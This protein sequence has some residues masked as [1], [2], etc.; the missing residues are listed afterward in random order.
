MLV[1]AWG[2]AAAPSLPQIA[3]SAAAYQQSIEKRSVATTAARLLVAIRSAETA[4]KTGELVD[5]YEQLVALNT[6]NFRAWLQLANAWRGAEPTAEKGLAAAFNAYSTA[7]ATPDQLEALLLMS[8]FLRAR[9]ES[10]R[11]EYDQ[12]KTALQKA[13]RMLAF[14]N[15]LSDD[16]QLDAGSTDKAGNLFRVGQAREQALRQTDQA[17]LQISQVAANLDEIYRELAATVPGLNS[18]Q[19]KSDDSRSSVFDV[20]RNWANATPRVD[21][22]IENADVRTCIQFSQELKGSGL[23]YR[24]FVEVTLEKKPFAAFGVDVKG[25]YLCITGLE[26]GK[27]YSLKLLRG[28]PAKGDAKLSQDIS[29]ENVELPSLPEQVAFSGRQFILPSNGSGEV[30]LLLTNVKSLSLELFRVTD[31]TLH[32]HIALGHI[33]GTIPHEEYLELRDRFAEPLWK[34]SIQ[35]AGAEKNK[36]TKAFLGVR[37][38]LAQRHEWLSDQ[39]RNNRSQPEEIN[40]LSLPIPVVSDHQVSGDG[41]FQA[42]ALKFEAAAL[43]RPAPGIYALVTRDLREP[44][45]KR[46]ANCEVNCGKLLVQWFLNTDIGLSL[47]EG[48]NDFTVVAR[49]LLSGVAK[50]NARI[51]LISAGNRVLATAATDSNGVAKFPRSL[52]RG[53]Q[54]NALVAVF[55]HQDKDFGFITFGSERLNLSRLNLDG[56]PLPQGFNAFLDTDR[57][58]YQPGETVQL[59]ALVRDAEGVAPM[60][61]PPMT[62]RLETRDQTLFERQIQAEQWALGGMLLPIELPR[63]IRP[64]AARIT[65]SVGRDSNKLIGEKLIDVGPIRPDRARLEFVTSRDG[66]RVRK[67]PNETVEIIGRINAQYLYAT[68]PGQGKA[69]DLKAEVVVKIVEAVSPIAGCY[70]QF[71]FGKFDDA[72]TPVSVRH[73]IE[74]TDKDGNLDLRLAGI[75]M[76]ASSKPLAANVEVTIFDAAGPLASRNMISP[77]IEEKNWIGLSREPRLRQGTRSGTVNLGIDVI[78][79]TPGNDIYPPRSL[80]FRVERERD[81]YVWE[82][83]GEL[84]AACPLSPT[85][86]CVEWDHQP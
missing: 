15:G 55:A 46:N 44:E 71:A 5:L 86:A 29:A 25:R 53:G 13:E 34:G 57:G 6:G 3:E 51:E 8:T 77:V 79:V 19:L 31:R 9:L 58:I 22:R 59:L 80:E 49:S 82:R 41:I 56:R 62:V 47:Y 36:P 38:L 45:A 42:G 85:R 39:I 7:R 54:S 74:Y 10:Y 4:R 81:L 61:A 24:E 69:R 37:S 52:T 60:R 33:G 84:V 26:A 12:A 40:S 17:L 30:P 75:A 66:W 27:T 11:K 28:L 23:S 63:S 48:D 73:F 70:E 35:V 78:G 1:I 20:V 65:L 76:P 14:L 21:F 16:T 68:N 43:D 18:E 83:Q 72:L 32:R 50:A 64:G 2:V 67:T